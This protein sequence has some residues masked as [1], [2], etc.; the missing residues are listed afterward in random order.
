MKSKVA[1]YNFLNLGFNFLMAL[2]LQNDAQIKNIL[3][4]IFESWKLVI[5]LNIFELSYRI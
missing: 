3:F 4:Y 1:I 2:H 5:F